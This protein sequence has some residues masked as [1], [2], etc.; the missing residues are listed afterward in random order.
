MENKVQKKE[1]LMREKERLS[2]IVT[3]KMMVVFFAL[4][5]A[6]VFL[7]KMS[8]G[9]G[10][11]LKFYAALPYIQIAAAVLL[12]GALVWHIICTKR[13]VDAKEHVFSSPLLLGLSASLLFAA[14]LY[15][16]FGGAFRTI[17]ALLSFGLLFFV[18][19]IYAVD[20]FLCSVAVITGCLSASVI[21]SAGF[22]GMNVPVNCIAVVLTLIASV[23]CAFAVYRLDKNGKFEL[24]GKRLKKPA[25]MV[26][27]A[28][29]AGCAAAALAVFAAL[30]FGHLLYCIAA[31]CVVYFIIAI[32]Y[33]VKLM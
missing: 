17:L 21:N 12:A 22:H 3:S 11:E 15:G 1:E 28:V 4:I 30:L 20:F 32:I 29:Y 19:Q 16:N 9:S 23:G 14:L 7:C 33:T 5:I 8:S 6:I 18:Y 25:H 10:I 27:A 24:F 26:P 31:V 13:G 2:N